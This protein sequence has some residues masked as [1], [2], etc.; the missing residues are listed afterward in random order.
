MK[1]FV[2]F[3]FWVIS[4][5]VSGA[6]L[7]DEIRLIEQLN[8][9]EI[10]SMGLDKLSDDELRRLSDWIYKVESLKKTAVAEA[11]AKPIEAPKDDFVPLNRDVVIKTTIDG[12]FSGWSGKTTFKLSN[13]Q[14]W[15]QRLSG[16]WR[17]EAESPSVEIKK[18]VFGY[19]VMR[20]ADKKTVGVSRVK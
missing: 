2:K 9:E 3:L 8:T 10:E 4:F 11:S 15:Q 5:G 12:K 18:N 13:G 16:R 17:F 1:S 7:S 20:V 6:A 19:Y 14:V